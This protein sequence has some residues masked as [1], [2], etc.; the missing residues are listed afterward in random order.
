MKI[1]QE[2]EQLEKMISQSSEKI[3]NEPID[4]INELKTEPT[5]DANFD[6]IQKEC[7]K[8]AKKL[9]RNATGL[10]LSD[11]MVKQNPYLKNKMQLDVISLS[12]MLYQLQVNET[13]QKTLME[14]VRNGA[15]HPRMFEVFAGLSKTISDVNKQLLQTME[16]IKST[17]RDLR[18]DI[19][20]K[21]EN[22]QALNES[23]IT[24]NNKGILALGTK[25]L[26]NE[27]KTIKIQM[28]KSEIQ[29][30]EEIK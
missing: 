6:N 9:I 10:M 4:N 27:M 17:Y 3:G 11:E 1:S 14:E 22:Q 20:D 26:I 21:P 7:E 2:R 8:R 15:M 30:V 23:G 19:I 28:K 24:K 18:N 16:A 25:E 13:M 12:G 5:F 29:D